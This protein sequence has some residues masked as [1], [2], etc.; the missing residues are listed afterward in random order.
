MFKGTLFLWLYH[1]GCCSPSDSKLW[2]WTWKCCPQPATCGLGHSFSLYR[3]PSWQITYLSSL[4][5]EKC[6]CWDSRLIILEKCWLPQFFFVGESKSPC[7][8]VLF[9]HGPNL[10]Q[11]TLYYSRHCPL[12][13]HLYLWIQVCKLYM[14]WWLTAG[15]CLKE[16]CFCGCTILAVVHQVTVIKFVWLVCI[17]T[18]KWYLTFW[19][20][21]NKDTV[22]SWFLAIPVH[23]HDQL[24][25]HSPIHFMPSV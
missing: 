16:L 3:P 24:W 7:K 10:A 9:P 18:F 1:F 21:W 11:R 22:S 23:T 20:Y 5:S 13:C 17:M 14:L 4:F 8:D 12:I 15:G 6:F 19:P 2:P 25:S